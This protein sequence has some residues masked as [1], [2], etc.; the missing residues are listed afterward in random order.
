MAE[1][2]RLNRQLKQSYEQQRKHPLDLNDPKQREDFQQYLMDHDVSL[3]DYL[4]REK[5]IENFS[6]QY[7]RMKAIETEL[8]GLS[9]KDKT[10]RDHN[11]ESSRDLDHAVAKNLD[12]LCGYGYDLLGQEAVEH[13]VELS[14]N[15][16]IQQKF[17]IERPID[18]SRDF[19]GENNTDHK[20][21]ARLASALLGRKTDAFLKTDGMSIKSPDENGKL[22]D[23]TYLRDK[24]ES[25]GVLD[26]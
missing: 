23:G 13:L 2:F 18:L 6:K 26:K 3:N 1:N 12:T 11:R 4:D 20:V 9:E 16:L 10:R 7:E 17:H 15:P 21:L 14:K 22:V 24:F 8:A 25:S 19:S 5:S